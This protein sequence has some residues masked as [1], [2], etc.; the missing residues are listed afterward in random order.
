MKHASRRSPVFWSIL[1]AASF[2]T[3]VG[4]GILL[5][6]SASATAVETNA[7]VAVN[8]IHAGALDAIALA[9][10]VVFGPTAA[11]C[12]AAIAIGAAGLLRR[13]WVV[14]LRMGV[15]LVVPWGAADLVKVIVRRPRPDMTLLSHPILVEPSTFSYP[16]GHTAFAAALGMSVVLMLSG[17]RYRMAVLIPAVLVAVSTAWSRVYL[18]AHYPSDVLASLIL[19]PLLGLCLSTLLQRTRLDPDRDPGAGKRDRRVLRGGVLEDAP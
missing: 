10:N 1:A 2:L 18:G 17:R 9:I 7:V 6:G 12:I 19:V 4:V 5:A 3:T 14:A 11:V 15:L 13:S 8:G 16:S